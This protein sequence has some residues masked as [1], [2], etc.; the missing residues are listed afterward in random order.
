ML[1]KKDLAKE[2]SLIVQQ[3]IKNHND[4]IL[5]ANMSLDEFRRKLDAMKSTC[6][7]KDN[8]LESNVS[9]QEKNFLDLKSSLEKTL[10]RY[11]RRINDIENITSVGLSGIRK[12]LDERESYF[13]TIDGFKEFESKVDQWLAHLKLSFALQKDALISEVNKV[14]KKIDKS[15]NDLNIEINLTIKKESEERQKIN[16]SLDEFA[17]TFTG[18][19]RELE[20]EKKRAFIIEKNIENLYTIIDRIKGVGK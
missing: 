6:E 17:I 16:R 14:S 8:L 13:L 2:F 18:F 3:E 11:N 20:I 10:E 1:Q 9:T 19:R 12:S 15:I 5:A 7:S 4:A